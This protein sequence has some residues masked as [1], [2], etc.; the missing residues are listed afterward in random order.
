MAESKQIG[1]ITLESR[2]VIIPVPE[3]WKRGDPLP[4]AVVPPGKKPPNRCSANSSQLASARAA[5]I[6]G[7]TRQRLK[8]LIASSKWA[9]M[10][11]EVSIF[12]TRRR[13]HFSGCF[14]WLTLPDDANTLRHR[15]SYSFQ[16]KIV[17]NLSNSSNRPMLRPLPRHLWRAAQRCSKQLPKT[18]SKMKR[19]QT[20]SASFS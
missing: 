4:P 3:D 5:A 6:A 18:P 14:D 12:G 16:T 2:Y 20:R 8:T 11:S 7:N 13:S 15:K 10:D 17:R 1:R 19:S 9:G